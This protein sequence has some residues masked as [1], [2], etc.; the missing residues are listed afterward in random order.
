MQE[1]SE[2]G[3]SETFIP[4]LARAGLVCSG[5]APTK[6]DNR[7]STGARGRKYGHK[8]IGCAMFCKPEKIDVISSKRVHLKDFAPLDKCRSHDF[9]VDIQSKWNSM[10]MMLVRLKPTNQLAIVANTHLFWNPAREDIKAVQT[11]AAAEALSRFALDAGFKSPELPPLIL[12]GDFNTMPSQQGDPPG[13][14]GGWDGSDD[15]PAASPAGAPAALAAPVAGVDPIVSAI[16]IPGSGSCAAVAVDDCSAAVSTASAAVRLA[17]ATAAAANDCPIADTSS[18]IFHMLRA[19]S[20]HSTHPQHPDVWYPGVRS[21]RGENPRLGNL[22]IDWRLNNAYQLPEFQQHSPLFTTKTDDF[23]GWIDHIWVCNQVQVNGVMS[24]PIRRSDLEANI[25]NR[26]FPPMP[27]VVR[28]VVKIIVFF[29]WHLYRSLF[30]YPPY[31]YF[32]H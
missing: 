13:W 14:G 11:F 19:G 10:V 15:R 9:Y 6:I 26:K 22:K 29:P 20:L 31:P 4:G 23:T 21:S 27:N 1:V 16:P 28:H 12:C 3:L 25:K 2:K 24:P 32:T 18:A 8:H 30:Q 7:D 5:Y 17:A